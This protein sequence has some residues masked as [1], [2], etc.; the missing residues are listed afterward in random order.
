MRCPADVHGG[1]RRAGGRR[2][3]RRGRR[4]L[5]ARRRRRPRRAVHE[6]VR[7]APRRRRPE[8]VLPR[9]A[10]PDRRAGPRVLDPLPG[11][12]AR[13]VA[14]SRCSPPASCWR[15][16]SCVCAR[17][18]L[19]FL[20]GWELMT[21]LSAAVILV[22]RA[23]SPDA[24]RTVFT[25]ASITHLA[26]AGDVDLDPA[27]RG[28]GRDREYAGDQHRLG[29]AARDRARR[30][31]RDGREGRADAAARVAAAHASDRARAG[32]GADERGDDQGRRLRARARAGRL[33]R[34]AAVV[35]RRAR[36]R[37]SARSRPSAASSTR[38]SSTT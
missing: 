19:T 14:P 35:V 16:P 34:R 24:R 11:A 26:G 27:A 5:G 37:R 13:R 30:A 12:G 32:V 21:I 15:S 28:G 2:G 6:L 23:G 38:S 36:A 25:Y 4:L 29:P 17:D 33:G 18:P 7:A 9:H 8:R 10:R 3:T 22:A 20:L 1:A 31:D